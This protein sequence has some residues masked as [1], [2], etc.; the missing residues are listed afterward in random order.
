MESI[1][2]TTAE[3]A[4]R[5]R[6]P[7]WKRLLRSYRLHGGLILMFLP[8][9]LVFL[10]FEYVP[11][12]GLLIAFKDYQMLEGI[13][14][15]A[16]VGFEHFERLFTGA[17]FMEALQNTVV[18]SLLKLVIVFPAP[19]ILALMLNEVRLVLL[20]KVIQTLSY[21]PHFFSWVI[22]SGILFSFLGQDGG[23]NQ[24]T[25]WFG[26]EPVS[27]LLFPRYFYGI[28]VA[29]DIW[30]GV[31]WGSIVYFAAL[32]SIDPTLYDAATVDGASRWQQIWK[33]TLPSIMP[34]VI[35][36]FLLNISGFLSVGFDQI[37]NLMTPTTSSVAEILDTYVLRRLLTMDY[38][39]GTAAGI[40]KSL[41]G[42]TLVLTA[43][44]LVKWYDRDQGLW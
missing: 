32:T 37:Y 30:Q 1:A 27:W 39:L 24:L 44:R 25:G 17:G 38:S 13:W 11:I 26:L 33:I 6:V 15:S 18:I 5:R 29:S 22:L 34:T 23:F 35:I 21:L 12:Y 31:G 10:L 2:W 28:V 42:L 16:W 20:R 4:S 41:V 36:M 7:G 19:V 14:G 8:G 40:F 9:F 3:Q 43:N